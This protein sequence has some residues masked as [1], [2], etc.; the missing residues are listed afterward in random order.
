MKTYRQVLQ[1][2]C[3]VLLT[4]AGLAAEEVLSSR[5]LTIAP[6]R[7]EIPP[8]SERSAVTGAAEPSALKPVLRLVFRRG[9]MRLTEET[10][11]ALRALRGS[12]KL[13]RITGYGDAGYPNEKLANLRARAVA[14]YLEEYSGIHRV[15]I[16]WRAEAYAEEGIGATITEEKE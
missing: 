1:L 6:R 12:G 14:S 2:I 11:R 7:I 8:A 3:M 15:E 10:R 5:P 9:S 16:V 4:A 13:L